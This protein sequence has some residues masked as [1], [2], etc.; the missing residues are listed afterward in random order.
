[1]GTKIATSYANIFMGK[2]EGQLLALV[3]LI[4]YQLIR[5]IDD[6][7]MDWQYGREGASGFPHSKHLMNKCK[8]LFL[9]KSFI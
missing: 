4:S 3:E 6:I 1:M 8:I 2:L 9:R 7:E 5:F